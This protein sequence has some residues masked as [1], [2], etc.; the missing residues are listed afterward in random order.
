VR[1]FL[2]TRLFW[3]LPVSF[4]ISAFIATTQTFFLVEL[5]SH[6]KLFPTF[7]RDTRAD[8]MPGVRA[9]SLR[10]RGVIWA[11]SA[12]ICPI[13]SLVLLSFVPATSGHNSQWPA[14]LLAQQELRSAFAIRL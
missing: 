6:A 8:L 13:A 10:G 11:I 12:A 9:L 7:F 3:H 14:V 4:G 2:N 5:A 1:G